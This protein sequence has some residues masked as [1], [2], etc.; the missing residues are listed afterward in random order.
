MTRSQHPS[1]FGMYYVE[2]KDALQ[3]LK[4]RIPHSIHDWIKCFVKKKKQNIIFQALLLAKNKGRLAF[5][6]YRTTIL[7]Q[8]STGAYHAVKS[9]RRQEI[10]ELREMSKE[11]LIYV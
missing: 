4:C 11:D 7:Y 1:C 9:L 8:H 5:P 10:E 3:G 2:A 6:A